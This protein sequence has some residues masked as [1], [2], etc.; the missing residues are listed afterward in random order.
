MYRILFLSIILSISINANSQNRLW[1]TVM[2]S[3]SLFSSPRLV[4]LNRDGNLDIVV[5]G[6]VENSASKNGV[7]AIDGNT[8]RVLWTVQ[9][10]SQIY[11]SALFQDI[12]GDGI[13]DVFIGGRA[14]NYFAINGATGEVIWKF[15]EGSQSE[16]RKAGFLN[17][18]GTQF[19]E[20]LDKDGFKDL[21]LT[22]G[23]DYLAQKGETDRPTARLMVVSSAT[24]EI[25]QSA[26]M[27]DGKESY[28]AP[29]LITIEGKQHVV[30]GTGGETIGGSL[31]IA[32]YDKFTKK[33]KLKKAKVLFSDSF[34]GF[35]LNSVM[36]DL[37][38]DDE[39][40]II[41]A[42]M[43]GMISAVDVVSGKEIWS[44][45]FPGKECYVTPALGQFNDDKTPDVFTI[46]ATGTFP[47]YSAFELLILDGKTGEVI[48]QNKRGFNQF[49]PA[50]I[51]NV[52]DDPMD[53]I[54]YLENEL[55][56]VE[57]FIVENRICV[58]DV[59]EEKAT[60]IG[61]PRPGM[62]M[63]SAPT[64]ADL[65][66][67]GS[68]EIIVCASTLPKEQGELPQGIIECIVLPKGIQSINWPGYLGPLE[69]GVFKSN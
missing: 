68:L 27:P 26:R 58:Y 25:I 19:V 46:I 48:L 14:A 54:I 1:K 32:P 64:I 13:K 23:G 69:N 59:E 43:N 17:F 47:Q 20:D 39:V 21:L 31:F 53:E 33:G 38:S 29:H 44:R 16:S 7:I 34:K 30:F 42:S 36:T 50:I 65:N 52:D 37:N 45:S 5:G 60:F 10:P 55:V 3:A 56:H 22:N 66:N 63:A 24:G 62:S 35:I 12:S 40:D 28:Y 49:S 67:N 18:F 41:T 4:D 11:T 57:S 9:S 51:A 61:R 2:D 8:G 6:G 15:F